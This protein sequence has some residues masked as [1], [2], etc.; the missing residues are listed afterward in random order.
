MNAENQALIRAIHEAC[1]NMPPP[2]PPALPT[3]AAPDPAAVLRMWEEVRK[4]VDLAM[5]AG[6]VEAYHYVFA[7]H[8]HPFRA[9]VADNWLRLGDREIFDG[10]LAL[11]DKL[12]YDPGAQLLAY[13]FFT[14]ALAMTHNVVRS[15]EVADRQVSLMRRTGIGQQHASPPNAIEQPGTVPLPSGAEAAGADGAAGDEPAD[16]GPATAAGDQTAAA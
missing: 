4:D 3:Y 15:A 7:P 12:A 5:D 1:G 16:A 10:A 13:E 14:M 11:I 6:N 8:L 9:H 2:E